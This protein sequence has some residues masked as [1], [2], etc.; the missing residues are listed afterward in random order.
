MSKKKEKSIVQMEVEE[1]LASAAKE[2]EEGSPPANKAQKLDQPDIKD[3]FSEM[4][5]QQ[6]ITNSQIVKSLQDTQKSGQA[7]VSAVQ[8][9]QHQQASTARNP[10]PANPNLI[11]LDESPESEDGDIST[12]EG[13]DYEFEG[14][15]IPPSQP[16][17]TTPEAPTPEPTAVPTAV[18]STSAEVPIDQHLFQGYSQMPNW[19]P[20]IQVLTWFS[21]VN[22]KEVPSQVS[23]DLSDSLI[24]KVE[25][26]PL[27]SPP[28][29]PKAIHD[30]LYSAPK[31]I[32]KIPKMVNE[33][34]LKA[35]KELA[36]ANKTFTETLSFYYSEQF[37][38]I[39]EIIPE[40]SEVLENHKSL[41]SQG[42]ALVISASLKISKARKDALRPIFKLPAVLRQDPTA[43]QVLGTDD[44]ATL[45][46]KTS[47]EQKALSSVFRPTWT[48]RTRLKNWRTGTR[49]HKGFKLGRT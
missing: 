43:A 26:Q 44:L 7:V 21:S 3:L 49:P 36:I 19:N 37:I 8:S 38:T 1:E 11:Q 10:L 34:L 16:N 2:L 35:Q 47:K 42:M 9:L 22:N 48:S 23:K 17:A 4:I 14:W 15:D 45:S 20:A 24:P 25:F 29:L 30:R 27:F 40:I 32:S 28:Q 31:Y 5:R 18:A 41:L 12:D 13:E 46:E 6:A 39:K 33:H